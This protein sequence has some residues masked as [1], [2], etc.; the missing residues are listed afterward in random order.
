MQVL[1][2]SKNQE[3]R[4]VTEEVTQCPDTFGREAIITTQ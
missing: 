2:T 1:V 3:W 4:T